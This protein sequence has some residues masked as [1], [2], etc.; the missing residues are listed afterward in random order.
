[1][2]DKLKCKYL[3]GDG[4]CTGKYE[5]FRCIEDK[6]QYYIRITTQ[7][8]EHLTAEGYCKKYRKFYCAGIGNCDTEAE[9]DAMMEKEKMRGRK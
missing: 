4:K 6:C 3:D 5:G 2:A 8:C 1:M 7:V 9:Y